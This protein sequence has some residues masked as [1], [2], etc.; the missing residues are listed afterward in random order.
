MGAFSDVDL[1][2]EAVFEDLALKKTVLSV[3]L[4]FWCSSN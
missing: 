4:F 2:V 3:F 1:V